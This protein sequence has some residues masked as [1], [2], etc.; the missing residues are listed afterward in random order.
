MPILNPSKVV[1][2]SRKQSEN[3]ESPAGVSVE[4]I[5]IPEAII[6]PTVAYKIV[7]NS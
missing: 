4:I 6:P 1:E 3:F 2:P 7:E 5:K